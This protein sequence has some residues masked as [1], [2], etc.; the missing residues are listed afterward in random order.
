MTISL[1]F[2]QVFVN[3]L[4]AKFSIGS[5]LNCFRKFSTLIRIVFYIHEKMKIKVQMETRWEIVCMLHKVRFRR[6]VQE[7]GMKYPPDLEEK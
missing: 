4:E 2:T 5:G 1:E 6:R 7:K 3:V